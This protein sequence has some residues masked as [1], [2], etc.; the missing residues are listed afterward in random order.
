MIIRR[1][2]DL[3]IVYEDTSIFQTESAS[4][5]RAMLL[6]DVVA[7]L[8]ENVSD[9]WHSNITAYQDAVILTFDHNEDAVAFTLAWM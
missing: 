6:Y 4:R 9:H 5:L 3:I 8:D 2:S 1:D 7:W